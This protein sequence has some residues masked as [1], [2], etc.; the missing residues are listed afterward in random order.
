MIKRPYGL[1]LLSAIAFSGCSA[2]QQKPLPPID[3]AE[4][5]LV[6]VARSIES[7]WSKSPLR[8]PADT[9]AASEPIESAVIETSPLAMRVDIAWIGELQPAVEAL[10]KVAGFSARAV[11]LRKGPPI[12][13]SI[14]GV[15][16]PLLEML[17][18][19][20][21]QAGTRADVVVRESEATI[22]VIYR[23]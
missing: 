5:A 12:L 19:A 21:M 17:R 16:V 20:G 3:P 7:S 9:S 2:F 4:Q 23:D 18:Q 13:I 22:E 15:D 11:G 14:D 1:A 6:D 10:A 8:T